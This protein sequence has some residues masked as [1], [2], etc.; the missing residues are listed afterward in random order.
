MVYEDPGTI[1]DFG[2]IAGVSPFGELYGLAPTLHSEAEVAAGGDLHS[3]EGSDVVLDESG[4]TGVPGLGG[5]PV[6]PDAGQGG[7]GGV[8]GSEGVPADVLGGDAGCGG[9]LLEHAG[10]V[11][12]GEGAGP[13][14]VEVEATEELAGL[15]AAV[16]EPLVEGCDGIG[17][18]VVAVGD[19]DELS[20][21]FGVGLGL[22]DS[23]EQAFKFG[24]DVGEVESG[25]LGAA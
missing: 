3:F 12:A 6:Q 11:A 1:T 25:E 23:D 9:A 5:D 4:D 20:A 15:G 21:G 18:S 8:P 19:A 2:H 22:A 17:R 16:G 13:D 10:Q 7:G 24:F 14:A